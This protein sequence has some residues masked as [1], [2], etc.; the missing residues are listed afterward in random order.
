MYNEAKEG[1]LKVN[2]YPQNDIAV[3]QEPEFKILLDRLTK[4][5][6]HSIDLSNEIFRYAN[7]IKPIY[8]P[9]DAN[10]IE[11][12]PQGIIEMFQSQVRKLEKS[13]TKLVDVANHLRE[14]I[15]N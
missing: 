13:N 7:T 9:E 10:K 6:H 14:L 3:K 4:E 8:Q 15:G 11:D 5:I 2:S 12:N 1:N